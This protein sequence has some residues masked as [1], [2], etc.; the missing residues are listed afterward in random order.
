VRFDWHTRDDE[1]ENVGTTVR[2]GVD[3]VDASS[4][5]DIILGSRCGVCTMRMTT[6]SGWQGRADDDV[7]FGRDKQQWVRLMW[8]GRD[9]MTN[10]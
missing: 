6:R 8:R 4:A 10:R 1:V 5:N 9:G 2:S 7:R 3:N